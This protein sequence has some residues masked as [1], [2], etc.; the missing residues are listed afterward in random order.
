MPFPYV[1]SDPMT[2]SFAKV[3]DQLDY[4]RALLSGNFVR[5]PN[6]ETWG[7]TSFANPANGAAT[8]TN[9]THGKSGGTPA[10]ADISR[11]SS[12]TKYGAYSYKVNITGAGSANSLVTVFQAIANPTRFRGLTVN[13]SVWVR[14]ST[15]SKVRL[16]VTDG[17]TT[18]TSTDHTGGGAY[19]RL[20]VTLSVGAAAASLTVTVEITSN[21]TG[22]VYVDGFALY[23]IVSTMSS[24]AKAALDYAALVGEVL[25]FEDAVLLA[26][27]QAITGVKTFGGQLIGKGT[28]AA[29]NAAAGYIG[30][31]MTSATA[32]TAF[33]ATGTWGDL[34]SLSLTAGDWLIWAPVESEWIANTVSRVEF[35]I[36]TVSGNSGTGV[37]AGYSHCDTPIPN[38]NADGNG[39]CGPIRVSLASTTTYYLKYKSSFT[40]GAPVGNGTLIALRIR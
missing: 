4:A 34:V 25:Q 24:T 29:D 13:L 35:G 22:A 16:K 19:E 32:R 12:I 40:A 11:E 2:P 6:F 28:T 8:A 14:A 31:T 27:D 30:Q 26:G 36:G 21:F 37:V 33:P 20:Q 9:W 18:V 39:I 10:T 38:A 5:N 1:L 3:Q 17:T 7:T 23:E 15:A